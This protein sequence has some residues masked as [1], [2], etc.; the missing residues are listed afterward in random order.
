MNRHHDPYFIPLEPE[1]PLDTPESIS[2]GFQSRT[3][4]GPGMAT[5]PLRFVRSAFYG[6]LTLLLIFVLWQTTELGLF[7]YQL[8]WSLALLFS[9]FFLALAVIVVKAIVEFFLY[10]RDFRQITEL[11]EQAVQ[12]QAQR[13]A[14]P[15]HHWLPQLRKLYQGKPQQVPLEQVLSEMPDYSDDREVLSHLDVH[16]FR[17]II[18][19]SWRVGT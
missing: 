5:K 4:Q 3:F 10:Q 1:Q 13:M 8:H 15:K 7:L 14:A 2:D 12:F 9:V 11:R 16:F 17:R 6:L 18:L 19:K